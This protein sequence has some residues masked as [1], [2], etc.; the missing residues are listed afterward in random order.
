MPQIAQQ[1]YIRIT[2]ADFENITDAEKAEVKKAIANGTIFDVLFVVG[3]TEVSTSRV[4]EVWE[5]ESVY[6]VAFFVSG[7]LEAIEITK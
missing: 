3:T 7:S 1:D 2:I 5:N 4:V 6:D